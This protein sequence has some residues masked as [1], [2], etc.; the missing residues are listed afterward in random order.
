MQA[1]TLWRDLLCARPVLS[2]TTVLMLHRMMFRNAQT[3]HS[4]WE[5]QL[6]VNH[7]LQA[8]SVRLLMAVE[9]LFVPL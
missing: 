1:R 5:L 3:E 4:H 9:M 7:A 6:S 8:G 2:V